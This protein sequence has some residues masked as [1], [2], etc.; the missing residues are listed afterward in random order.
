MQDRNDRI[1]ADLME[2]LIETGPDGMAGVF[3]ALFNLAMRVEREQHLGARAYERTPERG[4][5]A[6]GF[7]PKRLDTAAGTLTLQVPKSRGGE[8]PFYPQSLERGR[9]ST[10]AVMLAIA[11]MY[12]QGVSTRDVEK[13]MAEFGLE[14]LSS[15]QVSRAAALLDEELEAW[16]TRPLGPL[17]Y[18]FLDARYEKMRVGGVVRDVAILSAIGIG[19]D[20]KRSVLG[21]SVALSEAEIHWR[22]F[23]RSLTDRGLHGVRFI[24]SDD[25][26]GLGIARKAVLPG[27]AWQRCQLGLLKNLTI[28]ESMAV[29]LVSGGQDDRTAESGSARV[30]RLRLAAGSCSR[31]SHS[32]AGGSGAR[33]ILAAGRGG[34]SLRAR[35]RAARDRAGGGGPP[36]ARR[37]SSR[38]RSRS[39]ADA[40]G[41]G[42]SGDPVVRWVWASGP[43]ARSFLA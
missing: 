25:H 1:V 21:L 24:T 14:S 13:V 37:V 23:I 9:R 30:F 39:A 19:E 5:Y 10:R 28:T 38:R 32:G 20:G 15:S 3:T 12:I 17:P 42:Q 29:G 16:R 40:R 4:G 36:D 27:A 34:R 6:N 18:L 35:R 8:T 26:A 31:R 33:S 43:A 2:Q 41:G 22:D 7:K 11:Q